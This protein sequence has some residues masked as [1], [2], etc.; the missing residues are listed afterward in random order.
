MKIG[1]Q[2]IATF[3]PDVQRHFWVGFGRRAHATLER[4]AWPAAAAVAGGDHEAR[5]WEGIGIGLLEG[6]QFHEAPR[7]LRELARPAR[8]AL[9]RGL[10]GESQVFFVPAA[11][12]MNPPR[13]GR[14]VRS[15]AEED[16]AVFQREL[17]KVVGMLVTQGIAVEK[18]SGAQARAVAGPA[19]TA[20]GAGWALYR[21]VRRGRA[22]GCVLGERLRLWSPPEGS[23][24]GGLRDAARRGEAPLEFWQGL[25]AAYRW[26]LETRSPAWLLGDGS[27][28]RALVAELHA[29]CEPLDAAE[30][31]CFYEAAG[32]AARRALRA[33]GTRSVS[34]GAWRWREAVPP[35]F[36][37]A[38]AAGLGSFA[39]LT[40]VIDRAP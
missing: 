32:A 14:F 1:S 9:R 36:Q 30:A 27:G 6:L 22:S 8:E 25:A 16:R 24:P 38:F 20:Y 31:A 3:P 34:R 35:H 19:Q 18:W 39:D 5:V 11:L 28:P 7:I 37:E 13:L 29:F 23:W 15:F 17:A 26:D 4:D 21:Q 10:A 12:G 33:P 2:Q 40:E